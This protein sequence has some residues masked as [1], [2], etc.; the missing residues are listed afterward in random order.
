MPLRLEP[1]SSSW[2]LGPLAGPVSE[3]IWRVPI[4]TDSRSPSAI[5][6]K[7]AFLATDAS[8]GPKTDTLRH[9][10]GGWPML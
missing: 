7:S 8:E 5:P 4:N 9:E 3:S 1:S 6:A 2:C 10:R